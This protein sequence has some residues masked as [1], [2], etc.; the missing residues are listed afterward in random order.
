MHHGGGITFSLINVGHSSVLN[1]KVCQATL[2]VMQKHHRSE[3]G[4]DDE[5]NDQFL[6][7][8]P[9]R[10]VHLGASLDQ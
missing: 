6:G 2:M 10:V 3:H 4:C 7:I 5:N 9:K 8:W 1:V